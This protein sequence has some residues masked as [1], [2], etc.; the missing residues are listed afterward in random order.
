[1]Q[2]PLSVGD[3]LSRA[4]ESDASAPRCQALQL[5]AGSCSSTMASEMPCQGQ[6]DQAKHV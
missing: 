4:E 6:A 2:L 3:C 1:M 5:Q